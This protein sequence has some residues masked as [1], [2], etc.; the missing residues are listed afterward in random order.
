MI[1]VYNDNN[2]KEFDE[3]SWVELCTRSKYRWSSGDATAV[4]FWTGF[5]FGFIMIGMMISHQ[6]FG[7]ISL[8]TCYRSAQYVNIN[9]QNKF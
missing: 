1:D 7:V 2:L 4:R 6:L 8:A 5:L 3:T 9:L